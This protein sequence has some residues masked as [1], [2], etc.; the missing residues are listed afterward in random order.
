MPITGLSNTN[1]VEKP[2]A[3]IASHFELMI[4]FYVPLLRFCERMFGQTVRAAALIRVFVRRLH[5]SAKQ[6]DNHCH[7]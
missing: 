7:C 6:A 3:A 2:H 5:I 4:M 1:Q